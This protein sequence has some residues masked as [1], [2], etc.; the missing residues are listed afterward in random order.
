[1]RAIIPTMINGNPESRRA[2]ALYAAAVILGACL[3]FLVQPLIARIILPWFGG[4]SSVWS[5]ALLFFQFAVL[6]GYA[7]AH[8]LTN[9]LPARAQLIVHAALLVLSCLVLPILPAESWR[10]TSAD[11]PTLR[12]L[13]L[14]GATVGLPAL[15]LCSTSPLL[16]VWY[17]RRVGGEAPWFLFALSNLGSMLALISFP[18]LLE[19]RFD[20]R[21]LA[22]GWSAAYVVYAAMTLASAWIG[23]V[24]PHA[25]ASVAATAGE[26]PPGVARMLLW[27]ALA[28]CA[29]GL[30]TSVSVHL[31]TNV[32]PIP[33]LWVAPLALYLLTFVLTFGAEGFYRRTAFFPW[34]AAAIGAMAWL[35]ANSYANLHIQYVIPLYL[36]A[37]FACC[38]A[39]HGELVHLRPAPSY[40]TRFYLLVAL[41][42]V[43]G[44]LFVAVIAP[45][46]FDTYLETPLLLITVAALGAALQWRRRGSRRTLLPVRLALIAGI[47]AL[48]V[49]TALTEL[50]ARSEHLLLRRNFYGVLRVR[51]DLTDSAL[52]SRH[53]IHGTI[54]H[55]SQF[56]QEP[57]RRTPGSYFA[58][59][60]GVGRT[61]Q[62]LQETGP[63][64]YGVV[65]LGAGVLASY[66]RPGDYLR[67][68]EINPD[69]LE[70]AARYFTFLADAKARGADVD[71][72]LGDGRLVLERQPRQQ[73][74]LLVVDA[75]SS[76]A[77]PTHLLTQEAVRLYFEHL[78][79]DG[80]LAIQISN[81]YLDLTPVIARA[82][83]H[84][85]RQAVIVRN[86]S[87]GI[88]NASVWA[89]ITTRE[90]LFGREAFRDA[91]M[92]P[93]SA[94]P[95]FAGW[96][97]QYSSLWPV[98]NLRA[99]SG[100]P[101]PE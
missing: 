47:T 63:V 97:D 78:K 24:G 21:T 50:S 67:L 69:V 55:G 74:D 20:V 83:E 44:G 12:I 5:A 42:G 88:S 68:Y 16:S 31:S 23:S 46:V 37:L 71:V 35:H 53:L 54:S 43:L 77:I 6:A 29:A 82:A 100:D 18:F 3:L 89:L 92:I 33:L 60:S 59:R 51:D 19:P 56:L 84:V 32:A 39:C 7:Y 101:P 13:A 36:A 41:G 81:R 26:R 61:L 64:R 94:E 4:A 72:L 10:T 48:L 57:H 76:D 15:V 1:V 9:A 25:A 75:F 90:D 98:L 14:L 95:G 70:I 49:S 34:L 38:L 30:L 93:A 28:G 40:L 65:G 96:T 86:A 73:F 52:A 91:R 62:V 58:L 87:D 45:A 80:V 99:G 8:W 79:P 22:L 66:A 11:D 2:L 27:V 85:D 17:L